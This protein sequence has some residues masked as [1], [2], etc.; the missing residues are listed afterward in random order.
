M[1]YKNIIAAV[2]IVAPVYAVG[3]RNDDFSDAID[4]PRE[5][6]YVANGSLTDALG[7]FPA[8]KE[9]GEPNHAGQEGTGSVWYS[10]TPSK[11]QRV[12]IRVY[13]PTMDIIL[14]VYHGDSLSELV[15]ENRYAE[16]AFP[17]F[18]RKRIEPFANAAYVEFDAKVGTTYRIAVDSE[19]NV[20]EPFSIR[21]EESRNSFKPILELMKAGSKWEYLLPTN[22]NGDPVDPL[23][24]DRQFFHTWMFPKRY[25]GPKFESG[26]S[27]VGYGVLDVGRTRGALFG[28][29]EEAPKSGACHSAYL[30][31]TFTPVLDV[32]ALGIEGVFDDGAII[33]VNGREAIR[34]NVAPEKDPQDWKTTA[35]SHKIDGIWSTETYHQYGVVTGL[36]LPAGAPVNLSVSLH[37]AHPHDRDLGMDLRVFALSPKAVN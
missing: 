13:A 34:F 15:L 36:R 21:L 23:E 2:L 28:R 37:N 22:P 30:R 20:H 6:P 4:L 5:I 1:L 19:N 27:P 7:R 16:Y 33:Y 18:S 24:L 9:T 29:R 12:S 3:P 31:T 17:A 26:S 32:S 10:W 25:Q 35:I 11:D 8:S 14:A